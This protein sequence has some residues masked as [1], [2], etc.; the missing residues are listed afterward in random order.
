MSAS[1]VALERVVAVTRSQVSHRFRTLSNVW[2]PQWIGC[3]PSTSNFRWNST[4]GQENDS[5]A[6]PLPPVVVY[7]YMSL[8]LTSRHL[9]RLQ[10]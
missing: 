8:R 2:Q 5:T 10:Q 9:R 6:P 4:V 1:R 3:I 7:R